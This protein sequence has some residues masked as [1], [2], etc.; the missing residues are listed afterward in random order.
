MATKF[1]GKTVDIHGGGLDLCFPHHECEIAQVT[2]FLDHAPYV[3]YWMHTAMVSYQGEK[4]S[5]SLGNLVMVDELMKSFS[6][7]ALRLYLGSHHYREAWS[8]TEK[9]LKNFQ[10][11]ADSLSQAVR[12]ESGQDDP[13][14]PTVYGNEFS[15]SM[16]NDLGT[17]GAV[18][19]L[20]GLAHA[21][22]E[23]AKGQ[24][25]VKQAQEMLRKYSLVL[26]LTLGT[27]S[28]EQRVVK[29]W[30]TKKR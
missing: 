2:P 1:L 21:I 19:A 3:R 14:S 30:N 26:G 9:D 20:Q 22:L 28:P 23:A 25:D 11:L 29:G 7:D 15:E 16:E 13:L 18:H 27:A 5:K 6:S 8:Y 4:M 24:R 12:V 17:P 10:K